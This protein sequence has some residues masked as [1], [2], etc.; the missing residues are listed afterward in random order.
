MIS[1]VAEL[2]DDT[3]LFF[4]LRKVVSQQTFLKFNNKKIT[5]VTLGRFAIFM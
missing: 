5:V 3:I 4:S 2:V 1:K